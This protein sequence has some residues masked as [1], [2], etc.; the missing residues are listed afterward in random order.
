VDTVSAGETRRAFRDGFGMNNPRPMDERPIDSTESLRS[1]PGTGWSQHRL[2]GWPRSQRM[3][4]L[5]LLLIGTALISVMDAIVKGMST[6]LG[7][8][9]ITW[10][11]Y[12]TSAILLFLVISP[13]Q[14]IHRLRTRRLPLHL[15]RVVLVLASTLFFFGA[16]R[17]MSLAEANA[18]AFTTPLMI[19]VLSGMILGEVV[20]ARRWI[21][22]ATGFA[23]VLLVVQPGSGV[24]GWAAVLPLIGAVSSALYHVT[25]RVLART[26]D[27][28]NTLYFVALLGGIGLSMA[29]PF[30]WAP[31][32][33]PLLLGILVVGALGT[34]GHFFVIRAFQTVPASTLSPFLYV[35]L[36]WATALGWLI[37]G[38][39]PGPATLLGAAIILGSGLYVYRQP[40]PEPDPPH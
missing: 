36:L 39:V 23:G 38:D 32:T 5:L 12:A 17:T 11:R 37:F 35:Y 9:Q 4:G 28:A 26:E 6:S 40:G 15:L 30:F 3:R 10:G 2:H 14:S 31:L 13:R 20:G 29:V 8:L 1:G 33:M 21:A 27:P 22:V 16:L 34:V 7:T 24:M 19:T 25:T 18:I